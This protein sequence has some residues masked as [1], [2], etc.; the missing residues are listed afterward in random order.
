[1]GVS[2]CTDAIK[3]Y[4]AGRLYSV[5]WTVGLDSHKVALHFEASNTSRILILHHVN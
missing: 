5:D 1:M 3:T 4:C 2:S